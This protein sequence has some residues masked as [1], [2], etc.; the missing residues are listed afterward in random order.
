MKRRAGDEAKLAAFG[1]SVRA[2]RMPRDMS[3]ESLAETADLHRTYVGAVERGER[4]PSLLNVYT[5]AGAL[6]VSPSEL[7]SSD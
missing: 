1:A 2:A 3:Q 4:N 6:G 5:L 7:L